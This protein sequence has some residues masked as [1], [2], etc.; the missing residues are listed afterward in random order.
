M[1]RTLYAL[2]V[3]INDY[4]GPFLDYTVV[5]DISAAVCL[6]GLRSLP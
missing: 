1:S 4:P 5:Y 3:G 2:L 6:P